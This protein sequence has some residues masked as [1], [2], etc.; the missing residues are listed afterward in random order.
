MEAVQVMNQLKHIKNYV[1]LVY[2]HCVESVNPKFLIRQE[3]KKQGN[4]LILRDNEYKLEKNCY[5][6]GFGKAALDMALA[7]EEVVGEHVRDGVI[8]VPEGIMSQSKLTPPKIVKVYEGAKGN[9][10]DEKALV[11]S[12]SIVSVIKMLNEK[13]LLLVLVSGGG[14]ALLPYPVPPITLEEKLFVTKRLANKGADIMELNA[15]RKRL[16]LVKGGG[17][18]RMAYPAKVV[19]LVIS[20]VVNDPLD[21][22]ASGPTV[23]DKM[24]QSLAIDVL[25][26]YDLVKA[27]PQHMLEVLQKKE[28]EDHQ[29]FFSNSVVHIIG[30]NTT[31]LNAGLDFTAKDGYVSKVLTCC[32]VGEVSQAAVG[33]AKL[34]GLMCQAL[35]KTITC[36][37]F[38]SELEKLSEQLCID[39]TKTEEL[40]KVIF[41]PSSKSKVCL[42]LGGET[43]V[44]VKGKGV[45]GRNQEL[46]LRFAIAIDELA[47]SLHVIDLFNVVLLCGG[48]DGIDG[49]TDAAGAIAYNGQCQHAVAQKL[50]PQDFASENNSYR[51]Y[52]ALNNGEDLLMH[53]MTGT[54]V[55][56]INILTIQSKV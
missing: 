41:E 55:M 2:K 19:S 45:G 7:S 38:A 20:D 42:L 36:K 21:V 17:L 48:T 5:I 29:K 26:K 37:V 56:D 39:K 15:V 54:N 51:Y 12:K 34:A 50:N 46:A 1:K 31:A 40:A 23:P 8:S 35:G 14:S 47:K 6:V 52:T 27:V 43:T 3:L 44:K 9:V 11:A 24:P 53:G 13:D 4:S 18:A 16:S 10:P 49:P 22:I 33:V 32:L 25:K 30:N 28:A